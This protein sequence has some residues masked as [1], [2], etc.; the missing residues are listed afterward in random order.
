MPSLRTVDPLAAAAAAAVAAVAAVTRNGRRGAV[1]AAFGMGSLN[2][3]W[4][5]A[6]AAQFGTKESQIQARMG[7]SEFSQALSLS[8][9][10]SVPG[11]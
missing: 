1:T 10:L 11:C 9:P 5:T 7:G 3:Y 2:Q 6:F 4:A 8:S